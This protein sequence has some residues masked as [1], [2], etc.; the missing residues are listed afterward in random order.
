MKVS[1]TRKSPGVQEQHPAV[2][3]QRTT[4]G[5]A[6]LSF[7]HSPR[8]VL[9]RQRIG[10]IF[11]DSAQRKG[12]AEETAQREM[13]SVQ[14][15]ADDAYVG[16]TQLSASR[17]QR[18]EDEKLEED[19]PIQ[20]KFAASTV[21][22]Q[23]ETGEQTAPRE[24]RTGMPDQL[25]VNLESM[26]GFDLSDVRVHRNS[27]RP[28]QLNA[29]A[30]AQGNEI[31]LGP[32]QEQH[33]P[34]EA[35]HVVQQRQGRASE[36]M[37]IA[38]VGVNDQEILEREAEQLGRAASAYQVASGGAFKSRVEPN[39]RPA[40]GDQITP[41]AQLQT[42]IRYTPEKVRILGGEYKIGKNVV[43]HLDPQ[44]PIQGT[45]TWNDPDIDDLMIKLKEW[46]PNGDAGWHRGHMLNAL[47][48][49]YAI[50]S[51]FMPI[52]MSVNE[53]HVE[54]ESHVKRYLLK[55]MEC[56]YAID[57]EIQEGSKAVDMTV[58][59]AIKANPTEEQK[60]R[61]RREQ[62]EDVSGYENTIHASI[63]QR[64][65]ADRPT[66]PRPSRLSP[67]LPHYSATNFSNLLRAQGWDTLEE[68]YE[69]NSIRKMHNVLFWLFENNDS[70]PRWYWTPEL[71]EML[72]AGKELD[73]LRGAYPL[74]ISGPVERDLD[75]LLTPEMAEMPMTLTQETSGNDLNG[76]RPERYEEPA[77]DTTK[78][79]PSLRMLAA[80]AARNTG[81]GREADEFLQSTGI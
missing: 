17:V 62:G 44:K 41:V 61:Y 52:L 43:A 53:N 68:K 10:A 70:Y 79:V 48:G 6:S 23:R 74:L 16:S 64:G 13:T 12:A 20:A 7:H 49:G 46:Y 55:G 37:Q 42:D 26:S 54:V 81:A 60:N 67:G 73:E 51:N 76:K 39:Y 75:Q 63:R 30:Y 57:F 11:G 4:L 33:L 2:P 59:T 65:E 21:L 72:E 66:S 27:D 36:T 78:V 24:N 69:T 5:D 80:R 58:H 47:F 32:G 8:Q 38:G 77:V 15:V 31:H 40:R 29:L 18:M 19:A 35:W 28:A 34:H 3:A 22:V 71:A 56:Q 50:Q 45:T 9:Q 14:R 25:K 1:V